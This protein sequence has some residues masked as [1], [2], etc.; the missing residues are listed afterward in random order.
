M[1]ENKWGVYLWDEVLERGSSEKRGISFTTKGKDLKATALGQPKEGL[2]IEGAKGWD[3]S[4]FW[5]F[6]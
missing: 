4:M 2:L 1:V 5:L 6:S 3:T